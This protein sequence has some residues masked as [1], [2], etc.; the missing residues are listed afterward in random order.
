MYDH[1]PWVADRTYR[2][3]SA[4]RAL[5]LEAAGRLELQDTPDPIPG[6]GESLV[7]VHVAG[8]GGSETLGLRSPG[9]RPLPSVMGHS[10]AGTTADGSRV[11]VNPL[12]GCGC[13]RYCAMGSMQLCDDWNLIGVQRNG[14]LAEQ[15]AV[16]DSALEGLPDNLSWEQTA[17]IEPFA[18]SIS[19]WD[20]VVPGVGD[21]VLVIGAGGLG[22]GLVACAQQD[23]PDAR[24]E[25]IEPSSQRTAAAEQMGGESSRDLDARRFDVV[26]DTVGSAESRT[27]ALRLADKGARVVLLGFATPAHEVAM[28]ELIRHEQRLIGSFAYSA[29]QFKRA[30]ELAARAHAQCV[31][32][33]DW[34]QVP[35]V[36]R[37]FDEG[38]YEIVR[39]ALR[40]TL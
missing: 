1:V 8:I 36:L 31:T 3:G 16:P 27:L 10:I 39:G 23:T 35:D 38:S 19:A 30:I 2:G 7:T 15:V 24:I 22:L 13:C 14:G 37:D 34:Q 33:L 6:P 4:V 20:K 40:P 17:F 28:N 26:F 9:I 12:L 11:A 25:F 21:R 32:N 5:V 29:D 18:N